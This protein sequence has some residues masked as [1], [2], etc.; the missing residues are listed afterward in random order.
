MDKSDLINRTEVVLLYIWFH[1]GT[2]PLSRYYFQYFVCVTYLPVTG[3]IG[4]NPQ[5]WHTKLTAKLSENQ[6]FLS[7]QANFHFALLTATLLYS[8]RG[9]VSYDV[10]TSVALFWDLCVPNSSNIQSK[11][12]SRC[13]L[14]SSRCV[15]YLFTQ[16]IT[17]FTLKKNHKT[18]SKCNIPLGHFAFT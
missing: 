1:K 2:V 16:S 14:F 12:F 11:H 4:K 18:N 5:K 15:P 10:V 8:Q 17:K 6:A 9:R 13:F 7:T 3:K